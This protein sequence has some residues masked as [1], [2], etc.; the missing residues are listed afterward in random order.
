MKSEYVETQPKYSSAYD[1]P[2]AGTGRVRVPYYKDGR[3]K[4]KD[5]TTEIDLVPF[6]TFRSEELNYVDGAGVLFAHGWDSFNP[7]QDWYQVEAWAVCTVGQA[8]WLPGER[9]LL[10]GRRATVSIDDTNIYLQIGAN[11]INIGRKDG[12]L[13]EFN[14]NPSRWLVYVQAIRELV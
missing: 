5:E 13:N 11:G 1:I 8:G 9:V 4:Y 10:N 3:W 6:E 2:D 12:T 7:G 14:L